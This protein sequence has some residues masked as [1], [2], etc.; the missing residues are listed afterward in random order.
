MPRPLSPASN[1]PAASDPALPT[2]DPERLVAL[3]LIR[4]VAVL[5]ILVM[6]I[7]GFALPQGSSWSD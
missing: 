1:A 3:D 2:A 4:G 5:G 6:N 7:E